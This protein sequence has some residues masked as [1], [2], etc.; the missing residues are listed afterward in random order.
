MHWN[1]RN[2]LERIMMTNIPDKPPFGPPCIW[3]KRGVGKTLA[4]LN[5]PWLPVH[6]ID[7]ENSSGDYD[8][9]QKRL[10]ELGYFPQEFTRAVCLSMDAFN[11][12]VFRITGQ[13]VVDGKLK[14]TSDGLQ[15][16]TIGIDTMGQVATWVAQGKFANA[17]A[18]KAEKMTQAI[19]GEV[20]DSL[21]N[22]LLML[23]DHCKF[24]I[25]T[26]HE[27]EY[28]KGSFSPRV[29]PG[30][31][32]LTSYS[33]RL[34]K[35]N[36]NQKLPDADFTYNRLPFFP[37]RMQQFSITKMLDYIEK[38]TDWDNLKKDEMIPDPEPIQE[39]EPG[40]LEEQLLD[41]A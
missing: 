13:E 41:E 34:I 14:K 21:R 35:S 18:A 30:V 7:I 39:E 2:S 33:I 28:P 19:W 6:I 38:P 10:I 9:H 20:R 24:I 3:G 29:N 32:E 12:E 17:S 11:R 8:M 5:S 1:S 25:M 37:P 31:L 4:T 16:G 27:R 36:P 26:A 23:Q 40:T 22:L 15:F